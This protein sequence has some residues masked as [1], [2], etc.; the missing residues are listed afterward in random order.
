MEESIRK[1]YPLQIF[2]DKDI[3]ILFNDQFEPKSSFVFTTFK[4]ENFI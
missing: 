2:K 4:M 1:K 3:D